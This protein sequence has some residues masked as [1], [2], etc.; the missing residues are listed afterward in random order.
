MCDGMRIDR[1]LVLIGVMIIV[2]SMTMATQYATTKIGYEYAI[3]HPSDSDIRFIASDN[4]SDNIRVLRVENN[5]T[6]LQT[7]KIVLGNISLGVNKTYSAAFG[8]VNEEAYNI[9]ITHINL[10]ATTGNDYVQ[11]WLHGDRD[12]R[13]DNDVTSVFMY[14]GT[15]GDEKFSSASS[16]W[17]LYKGNQNPA[18]MD[19]ANID[20]LWDATADTRYSTSDT[21]A[22]NNTDDYVWVQISIDVPSTGDIISS[23]S[24]IIYIHTRATTFED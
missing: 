11:I 19:G 17:G 16:A 14:D 12:A 9:T 10:S 6:A 3:V 1:R 15:N 20:T 24:G 23:Y 18:N 22:V 21:N 2:L 13:A 8:I 7:L 5:D 4:S